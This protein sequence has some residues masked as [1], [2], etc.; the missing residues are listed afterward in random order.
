MHE[1]IGSLVRRFYEQLWN[2]WDDSAV[3][4]T[5]ASDF[6][7]R[8]SL[9]QQTTGRSGWRAYR[10]HIRRGS[11]D[12]HNQI[13]TLV[14]DGDQAAARLLYSGTHTGPLL[15]FPPTGRRFSYSGAAF[16]T[17]AAGL[18]TDAW[19]LGDLHDL[20]RQLAMNNSQ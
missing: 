7:F 10:D 16:F 20:R 19:V 15:D 3:E 14:T 5:L 1:D 17:A 4:H 9:G 13:I 18:L 2:N 11:S 12:F 8:G 6:S